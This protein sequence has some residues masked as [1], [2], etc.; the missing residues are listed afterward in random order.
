MICEFIALFKLIN[1]E[2]LP[3]SVLVKAHLCVSTAS[4]RHRVA[5]E[6]QATACLAYPYLSLP[7]DTKTQQNLAPC[8]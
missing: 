3:S 5:S 4:Q 6:L 2:S 8:D 1:F 7:A